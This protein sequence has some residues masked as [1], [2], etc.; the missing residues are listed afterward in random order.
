MKNDKMATFYRY[1][2]SCCSSS[3]SPSPP[4]PSPSPSREQDEIVLLFFFLLLLLSVFSFRA[5]RLTQMIP[6][7]PFSELVDGSVISSQSL[8]APFL[9]LIIAPCS[10]GSR[11]KKESSIRQSKSRISWLIME[12]EKDANSFFPTRK[13][14]KSK[15]K[16]GGE[17]GDLQK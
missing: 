7:P 6:P 11:G 3:S 2:Y 12:G 14:R 17:R 10:V 13:E 4:S 9:L 8:V 15:G 5:L 1:Q 16:E